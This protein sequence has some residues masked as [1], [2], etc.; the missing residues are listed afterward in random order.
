[1]FLLILNLR[2]ARFKSENICLDLGYTR[3]FNAAT[4]MENVPLYLLK[5][6]YMYRVDLLTV[7][8]K[9]HVKL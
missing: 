6:H 2:D 1:M 5:N 9:G 3:K 8:E 7:H 4:E